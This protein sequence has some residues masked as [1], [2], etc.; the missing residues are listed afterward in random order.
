MQVQRVGAQELWEGAW[1][2]SPPKTHL[3]YTEEIKGRSTCEHT[4]TLKGG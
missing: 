4:H 3:I 1:Y 2:S